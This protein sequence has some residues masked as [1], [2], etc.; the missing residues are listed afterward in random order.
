MTYYQQAEKLVRIVNAA[1]H[2]DED[3]WDLDWVMSVWEDAL[4]HARELY[5]KEH[6]DDPIPASWFTATEIKG[7]NNIFDIPELAVLQGME[8]INIFPKKGCADT[9]IFKT[10]SQFCNAKGIDCDVKY[11]AF[12]LQNGNAYYTGLEDRASIIVEGIFK[13]HASLSSFNPMVD[14][15]N[16]DS[17][18][19][20]VATTMA[21]KWLSLAAGRPV[22]TVSNS[23]DGLLKP[24]PQ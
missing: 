19:A 8:Y 2:T 13:N 7:D 18:I 11:K 6:E 24:V 10:F 3:R 17:T 16:V 23:V 12:Y 20:D 22:D 14:D 4:G 5:L 9:Y 1:I 15:Y 21:V